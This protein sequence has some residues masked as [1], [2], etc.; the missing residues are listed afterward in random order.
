MKK[1]KASLVILAAGLGTRFKGGIKQ[2]TPVGMSGE[3]LI[4]YSIYD[5]LK[6]GFDKVIFIIRRDIEKDIRE[7]IGDKLSAHCEVEYCFQELGDIPSGISFPEG[8]TKPWGTVHAVLAAKKL[9][10]EPFVIINADDYYGKTS[11]KA[12][13]DYITAPGRRADEQCMGGFILGNT[14]SD[15]GT[16]TRGVCYADKDNMLS[17][18]TETYKISK[19]TDGKIYGIQ[20]GE[21]VS[22][23][24][25]SI[26]SM[27]MWGCTPEIIPMLEEEFMEFLN[28]ASANGTIESAEY[29]LPTAYDSL[30]TSK[31]VSVRIIPT[32]ERW[33]GM[34]LSEDSEAVRA[35]FAE[36]TR[37][38]DYSS[39]LF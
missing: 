15:N 37:N 8:R 12:L 1:Y 36:M 35:A 29:A 34:T 22:I 33:Y 25:N 23:P 10:A 31:R 2:L 16:V 32:N 21:R 20:N 9:I 11:Y 14:L 6:A 38:G 39:P 30:L 4:E 24:E 28:S 5:A 3:L 19:E 26:V 18:V 13:F 27:N 7:M 17:S